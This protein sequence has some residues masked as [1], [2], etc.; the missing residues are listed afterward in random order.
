MKICDV[1]G[2]RVLGILMLVLF[3]FWVK[4]VIYNI[5]VGRFVIMSIRGSC[6]F[7]S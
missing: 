1:R 2:M 5:V 7:D 6:V 4:I 3:F